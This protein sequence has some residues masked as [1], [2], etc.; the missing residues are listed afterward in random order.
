M[1]DLDCML[2]GVQQATLGWIQFSAFSTFNSVFVKI[3]TPCS[4]D[5]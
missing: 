5:L 2:A 3:V 1:W 4:T